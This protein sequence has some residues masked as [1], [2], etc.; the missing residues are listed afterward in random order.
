M[1]NKFEQ[2]QPGSFYHI[3]NRANGNEKLF[4]ERENYHFFLAKYKEYVHPFCHTYCY[5]L[6]PNHFHFLIQVKDEKEIA[7]FAKL[8]VQGFQNLERLSISQ[9]FSNFF[10]SYT[11]SFNKRYNRKGSLF[12]HTYKRK[13]ISNTEY[14]YRLVHYIHYNPVV[15]GLCYRPNDWHFSSYPTLFKN[16]ETNLRS[17]EVIEWFNG[18]QNFVYVHQ[19]E[20]RVKNIEEELQCG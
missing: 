16:K 17:L 19:F 8:N 15:A 13:I 1:Q 7:E 20:P 5:C 18:K 14:L 6:M 11:K 2:L 3:Y 12:M 10:N 4:R 9:Q